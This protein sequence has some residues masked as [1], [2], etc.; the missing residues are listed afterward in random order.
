MV[1]FSNLEPF[2]FHDECDRGAMLIRIAKFAEAGVGRPDL[3]AAFGVGR[4]TIQRAV[5]RLRRSGEASF[6]VPRRGRGPSVLSGEMKAEANRLLASGLSGAAVA[7]Q[8]GVATA[9]LN[10]N[11][12]KGWIGEGLPASQRPAAVCGS[13]R[14]GPAGCCSVAGGGRGD[15]R[16]VCG[17]GGPRCPGGS[18]PGGPDGPWGAEHGRSDAG[19]DGLSAADPAA[20]CGTASGGCRWRRAGRAADAAEGGTA[21]PGAG[22]SVAAEGLS[23]G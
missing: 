23:T 16:R 14:G 11:R 3:A 15:G 22:V 20:I 17:C 9:T 12:R 18:R 10:Y 5:N 4:S 19:V 8:L 7:R 21:E 13:G 2:D 6:H 1:Y